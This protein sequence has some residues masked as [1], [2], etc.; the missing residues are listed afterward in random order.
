VA[1][2]LAATQVAGLQQAFRGEGM[3]K[4]LHAG[5][6]ACAG[7]RSAKAAACGGRGA[8]NV[9]HGPAGFAAASDSTGDRDTA[10]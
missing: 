8:T 7:V 6:A 2:A 5:H 9:L 10:L 1:A 3:S 4:P